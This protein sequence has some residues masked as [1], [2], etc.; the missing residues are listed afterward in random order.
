MQQ[1]QCL[2]KNDNSEHSQSSSSR[3]VQ[4]S[5]FHGNFH[6]SKCPIRSF[7]HV[8][9]LSPIMPFKSYTQTVIGSQQSSQVFPDFNKGFIQFHDTEA[10]FCSSMIEEVGFHPVFIPIG[11]H[12]LSP[13]KKLN[14]SQVQLTLFAYESIQ[15]A[16]PPL[17]K[18]LI[19]LLIQIVSTQL[20]VLNLLSVSNK[21]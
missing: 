8:N 6:W 4:F 18:G 19:L 1:S 7:F 13:I 10:L 9:F 2:L 14:L 3:H 17:K 21:R 15:T 20:C 11:C 16:P 5:Y 12:S